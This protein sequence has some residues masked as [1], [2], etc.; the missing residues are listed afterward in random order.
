MTD[1]DYIALSAIIA[2]AGPY[3][4]C[5]ELYR[6][7]KAMGVRQ[8]NWSKCAQPARKLVY[9]AAVASGHITDYRGTSGQLMSKQEGARNG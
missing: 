9:W 8:A 2:R 6:I 4:V 7:L 1:K 3:D 5:K